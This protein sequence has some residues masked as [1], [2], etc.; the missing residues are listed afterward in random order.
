MLV[1]LNFVLSNS[2]VTP[3]ANVWNLGVVLWEISEFGKLPYNDLSDDEVIIRVLGE[4][5]HRLPMPV[6][7][8]PFKS[9]L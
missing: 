6:V 9:N 7:E 3:L 4:G 8:S 5:T 1:V 2:Q